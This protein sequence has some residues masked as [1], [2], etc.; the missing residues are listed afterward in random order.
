MKT[1]ETL[2][3]PWGWEGRER[4]RSRTKSGPGRMPFNRF[5]GIAG[6]KLWRKCPDKRRDIWRDEVFRPGHP[7]EIGETRE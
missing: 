2:K 4:N 5:A 1:L 6:A 3:K 7:L